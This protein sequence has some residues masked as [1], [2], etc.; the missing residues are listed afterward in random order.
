[1]GK[2]RGFQLGW[3]EAGDT[4]GGIEGWRDTQQGYGSFRQTGGKFFGEGARLI[5]DHTVGTL[6]GLV[7]YF[8]QGE[9]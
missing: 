4:E 5:S 3:R 2:L 9:G 1:M 7:T 8:A 6:P